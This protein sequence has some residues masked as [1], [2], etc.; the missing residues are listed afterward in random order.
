[1]ATFLATIQFTQ[2]GVESIKDTVDRANQF[3][4]EASG[5][6]VAV[7]AIYWTFGPY[8]GALIFQAPDDAT[9]TAAMMKLQSHGFVEPTVVRAFT[10]DEMSSVLG[11]MG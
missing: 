3:K 8:D 5:M 10:A 2:K 1:M 11:K 9:A 7:E 4:A 6:G